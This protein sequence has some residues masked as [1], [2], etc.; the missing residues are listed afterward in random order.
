MNNIVILLEEFSEL[1]MDEMSEVT[2]SLISLYRSRDYLPE[3]FSSQLGKMLI[4][5]LS[6]Y[7][8][9]YRIVEKE[10]TDTRYTRVLEEL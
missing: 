8:A 1:S 9:T 6:M 4:E 5:Q 2:D 3:W 7:Q 10:V